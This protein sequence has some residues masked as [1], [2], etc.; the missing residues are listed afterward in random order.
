MKIQ[1]W[2]KTTLSRSISNFT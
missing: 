1:L 2:E